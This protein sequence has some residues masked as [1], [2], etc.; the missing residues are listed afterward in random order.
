MVKL[1]NRN[2]KYKFQI[3]KEKKQNNKKFKSRQ[4]QRR[5]KQ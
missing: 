3:N 1:K 4:S 2:G 5:K